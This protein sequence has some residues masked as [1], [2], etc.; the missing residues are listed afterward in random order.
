MLAFAALLCALAVLAHAA[1]AQSG[2]FSASLEKADARMELA[3]EALYID[4]AADLLPGAALPRNL[5]GVPAAGGGW[6]ASSKNG[7]IREPLLHTISA[8]GRGEYHANPGK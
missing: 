8:G 5:S 1:R 7:E 3:R 4:L 2:V 6:L